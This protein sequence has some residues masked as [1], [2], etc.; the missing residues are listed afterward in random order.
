MV[1]VGKTLCCVV[2]R[3]DLGYHEKTGAKGSNIRVNLK[4]ICSDS[5]N[6]FS[7]RSI[8]EFIFLTRCHCYSF[9]LGSGFEVCRQYI[10]NPR[11]P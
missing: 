11:R 3:K 8:Y 1:C 10:V 4:G 7:V 2:A 9:P 6:P 5:M